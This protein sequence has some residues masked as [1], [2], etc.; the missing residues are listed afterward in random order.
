MAKNNQVLGRIEA[1]LDNLSRM[2]Y[3]VIAALLGLKGLDM[4]DG[5]EKPIVGAVSSFN[6]PVTFSFHWVLIIIMV[7][8][9]VFIAHQM[10]KIRKNN[11]KKRTGK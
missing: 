7:A 9:V 2:L 5:T 4:L 11:N 10:F 8:I 6:T 3:I 1:K